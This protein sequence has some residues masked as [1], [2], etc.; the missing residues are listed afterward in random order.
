MLNIDVE[1]ELLPSKDSKDRENKQKG[2]TLT[3]TI[4]PT[5]QMHKKIYTVSPFIQG[6][7]WSLLT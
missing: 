7:I 6:M 1:H 4:R 5:L 2:A 3:L